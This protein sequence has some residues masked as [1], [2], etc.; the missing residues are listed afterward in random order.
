MSETAVISHHHDNDTTVPS[1]GSVLIIDDEA[2]IRESLQTLL[3][4]DGYETETAASGKEGLVRAGEKPFDLILLDVALPDANGIDLLTELH[5]RDS[6][7]PVIIITAYGTVEN[8]VRAMQSGAA[9]FVQKP[10]DNEKLLADVRAAVARRKA[11]EEN[12][13]LKRALKQRYNFEN[14]IGKSEPMLK[15]FDLVAQVAPSRS[16]VLLQGESGTGKEL[17]AKAL[18]LNSPRRDRPFVP[19]NTGSMPPD[20]LESTLFGH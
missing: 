17:I 20:L 12:V 8:A 3:E 7:L 14:I 16:T 5:Q 11:E 19:V 1:V 9:N 15:I 2:A 18:H 6:G 10:W 4:M 13:Q